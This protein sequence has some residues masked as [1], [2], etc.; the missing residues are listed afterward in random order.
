MIDARSSVNARLRTSITTA[1]F[2]TA[3]CAFAPSSTIVEIS[4]GG[5][6]S[7]TNQPR[8]SRHLAAVLRPAPDR[9]VTTA[10]SIPDSD[11]VPLFVSHERRGDGLG[12]APAH[13]R[14]A[15]DLVDTGR[16]QAF[17]RAEMLDQ[18]GLARFAEA[19]HGIQC[20]RRHAVRPFLPADCDGEGVGHRRLALA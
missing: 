10:T 9:P 14:H 15:A 1:T 18:R 20:G 5:R 3:P 19:R 6:L 12:G 4:S 13:P 16:T 11:I 2:V 7:T 17:Q 8:S